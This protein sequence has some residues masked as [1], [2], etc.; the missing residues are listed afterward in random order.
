MHRFRL[1]AKVCFDEAAAQSRLEQAEGL[2]G[3]YKGAPD[4]VVG[5]VG[6]VAI[7]DVREDRRPQRSTIRERRQASCPTE[8]CS[9][10]TPPKPRCWCCVI[11]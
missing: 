7:W 8:V 11:A 5:A 10:P 9:T 3:L 2:L 6:L 1:L 4:D